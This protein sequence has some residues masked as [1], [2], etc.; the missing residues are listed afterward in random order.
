MVYSSLDSVV[1]EYM[2]RAHA[3]GNPEPWIVKA[4]LPAALGP[5]LRVLF[6][7]LDNLLKGI[8]PDKRSK[9]KARFYQLIP[10]NQL[11]WR[12]GYDEQF[13]EVLV[14]LLGW[15]WLQ[16]KYS[17]KRVGFY[18]ISTKKGVRT[19]DLGV[20]DDTDSLVA[21]MECK[22]INLSEEEKRWLQ[23]P[24][25]TIKTGS[26][27]ISPSL[28]PSDPLAK[29]LVA[30]VEDAKSQV[31]STGLRS[32]KFI[33]ISVSLDTPISFAPI[34]QGFQRLVREQALMLR[35]GGIE[36]IAFEGYEP[37]QSLEFQPMTIRGEPLSAT[38]LRERR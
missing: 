33:F 3:A 5:E 27:L 17:A 6:E 2:A 34:K 19:P 15:K 36:L 25:G 24:S 31:E 1:A 23:S 26:V 16:E 4:R 32:N 9:V 18:P 7:R 12:E 8:S 35:S 13:R 22:K 11:Q 30:I 10:N 29:K 37:S 21:V 38:V 20:W 28:E 14:E